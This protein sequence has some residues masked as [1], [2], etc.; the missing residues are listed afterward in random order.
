MIPLCHLISLFD[1]LHVDGL[2]TLH[3]CHSSHQLAHGGTIF[4]LDL[5]G[6]LQPRFGTNCVDVPERVVFIVR[7]PSGHDGRDCVL[8]IAS[9]VSTQ[10]Q[11]RGSQ[12]VFHGHE[13]LKL[14]VDWVSTFTQPSVSN[15]DV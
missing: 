5:L 4:V 6:W 10:D 1:C 15:S 2:T 7:C 13:F 11:E 14:L 9:N 12:S 8:A 3:V